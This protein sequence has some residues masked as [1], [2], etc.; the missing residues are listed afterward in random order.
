MIL[1][2]GDRVR[3]TAHCAEVFNRGRRRRVNWAT[4]I[5]TVRAAG[6]DSAEVRW[7]GC[8]SNDK[9]PLRALQKDCLDRRVENERTDQGNGG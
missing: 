4:R 2:P 6:H 8:R 5:G 9:W 1:S 7:D 3:L